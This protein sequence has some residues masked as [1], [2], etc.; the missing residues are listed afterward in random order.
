M[1]NGGFHAQRELYFPKIALMSAL[2]KGGLGAILAAS[3]LAAAA[4]ARASD[5]DRDE[6]VTYAVGDQVTVQRGRSRFTIDRSWPIDVSPTAAELRWLGA[7]IC[8]WFTLGQS[9]PAR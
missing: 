5:F 6:T 4:T 3:L 8:T 9:V 7:T 2:S 1:R